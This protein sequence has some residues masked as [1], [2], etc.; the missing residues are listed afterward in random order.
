VKKIQLNKGDG[1]Y[2]YS[3]GTCPSYFHAQQLRRKTD[4]RGAFVVAYKNEE[5][6][7]AYKLKSSRVLCQ[8]LNITEFNGNNDKLVFS[9]QIAASS[10]SLNAD[11]LKFVYCGNKTIQE[12]HVGKWYKYAVGSFDNYE[13]AA[14]LKKT[15]CVPGAFVVAYEGAKQ[16][17][18]K[19]AI[20]K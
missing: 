13:K 4:V 19:E 20:H 16:I 2:R 10:R 12:R 9:V 8:N 18:I 15:I 5:R 7:N 11:D 1:W 14:E 17:N 3:I 6:V